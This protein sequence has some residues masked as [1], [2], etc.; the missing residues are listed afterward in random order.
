MASWTIN[1]F[2][3]HIYSDDHTPS[4]VHVWK[5]GGKMK[6]HLGSEDE[7]PDPVYSIG[8]SRTDKRRAFRICCEKQEFF[9]AE[10]RKIHG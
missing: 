1:G 4:H 5:D 7:P 9:L 3:F 8:M 6:I 2:K 10:W